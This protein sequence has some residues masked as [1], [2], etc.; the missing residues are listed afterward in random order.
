MS[1]VP[2]PGLFSDATDADVLERQRRSFEHTASD[3]DRYRP[4]Y[5]EALF[6]GI[7]NYADLAPDDRI[8]EVG[9]GTGRATVHLAKWGNPLLAIEPAPAM[10]D[11]ARSH[12]ASFPNVDVQT[13]RF[14]DG[15][16]TSAFGLVAVAQAFHWLDA[17]TRVRR[18]ADA[19]YAHGTAA[20]M[21]NVQVTP[22]HNLPFFVRVQDVYLKHAPELAHKGE[23][24]RPD[25]LPEHPLTGSDLFTDL[26]QFGH[27]WHWTL[28][29]ETYIG[30]LSTHSP[31]AAL[32]ADVRRALTGDI[33]ELIDADFDGHVSEYYVAMAG[34][35]RRA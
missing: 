3:Y 24:R 26:R 14:E 34:V 30:L 35:A 16:E 20:I 9:A 2:R 19:L 8:L 4:S 13:S 25:N 22:E 6:D 33:A 17:N 28:P 7:R 1:D 27:P 31:H 10:A 23:F 32:D 18:I 11:V 29:T 15:V 21:S 5:P 12:L